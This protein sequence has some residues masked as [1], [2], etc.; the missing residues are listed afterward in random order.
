MA[1]DAGG[2]GLKQG[3]L[4]AM[5]NPAHVHAYAVYLHVHVYAMLQAYSQCVYFHIVHC[6]VAHFKLGGCEPLNALLHATLC[7]P[8][9]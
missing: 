1:G 7:T 5:L 3:T 6:V 2:Y 9:P 4:A 8:Q